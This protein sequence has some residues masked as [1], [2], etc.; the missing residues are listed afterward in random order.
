L[1]GLGLGTTLHELPFQRSV[2]EPESPAPTAQTL[3]DALPSTPLSCPL[4]SGVLAI[5]QLP[6]FQRATSGRVN[7]C[8][9]EW[10]ARPTA[11]ASVGL[12]ASTPM[13]RL[14]PLEALGVRTTDHVAACAG[15]AGATATTITPTAAR[16]IDTAPPRIIDIR[17]SLSAVGVRS[18][19]IDPIDHPVGSTDV[20]HR[21]VD[22]CQPVPGSEGG[23]EGPVSPAVVFPQLAHRVV[24]RNLGGVARGSDRMA[25]VVIV[26]NDSDGRPPQRHRLDGLC[27]A[28][29][30][31]VRPFTGTG[32]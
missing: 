22:G 15:I 10:S 25:L 2:S 1:G 23:D 11:H 6:P 3:F 13:N 17:F 9:G 14:S 8:C 31:S 26:V 19:S 21:H 16:D 4:T 29:A 27:T 32:G 24:E 18:I 28:K 20:I 30:D 5:V 7:G 12:K